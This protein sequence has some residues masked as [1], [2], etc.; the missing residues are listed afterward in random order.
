[1]EIAF[2]KINILLLCV[3]RVSVCCSWF[4]F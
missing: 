3:V 4:G 2:L 1:M